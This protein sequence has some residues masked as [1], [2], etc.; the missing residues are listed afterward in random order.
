MGQNLIYLLDDQGIISDAIRG[1]FAA[2][3]RFIYGWIGSLADAMY[4][5]A[6]NDYLG[7]GSYAEDFAGKIFNILI[8]FMIFKLTITF[9]NYLVNPD[10][11]NDN[12]KGIQNVIKRIIICF[13]LLISINPIFKVLFDVQQNLIDDSVVENLML[14]SDSDKI[15]V[16]DEGLRIYFTQISPYCD[17]YEP[18]KRIITFS[19]GDHLALLTLKPFMQPVSE[20]VGD[21]AERQEKIK[22]SGYCGTDVDSLDGIAYV[23]TSE[24]AMSQSFDG[25]KSATGLLKWDIYNGATGKGI[26][27]NGFEANYY[28]IDFNYFIALIVGI[29]VSLI[30]I[31][32]CFDII[33]RAFTLMLLQIL[34]PIPIISY[35]SPGGKSADMLP[36]WGKK[37]MSTWASLFIRIIAL[38]FALSIISAI[39]ESGGIGDDSMGLL[40][41]IVIILGA[42]MFAKK[43]PQL[44]EELFPGLKLEGLKLN[45][46][47]RISEDAVGGKA[48]LGAGAAIG[49]AGLSAGANTIT[50]VGRAFNRN[51]WRDK[52]GNVTAGSV[53]RGLGNTIGSP[54]A[55]AASAGRRAFM[56][57]SRDGRIFNGLTQGHLEAQF[58][59]QQREDLS[60]KGSTM[61]GR[62]AADVN[63]WIGRENA[64]QRLNREILEDENALKAKKGELMNEKNN[65][66]EE[67]IR[68][69]NRRDEATK[70]YTK[71]QSTFQSLNDRMDKS[72][73]VD[74]Y[75]EN[76]NKIG[77][78][79]IKDEIE[80]LEWMKTSDFSSEV[81]AKKAELDRKYEARMKIATDAAQINSIKA[82]LEREKSLI[83]SES[84]K[85]EKLK[86][87][88]DYV[89]Q[90]RSDYVKQV[91]ENRGKDEVATQILDNIS[92][93]KANNAEI[94]NNADF[95]I[96]NVD[97]NGKSTYNKGAVY[98]AADKV[99]TI[100]N[101][102]NN[103]EQVLNEKLYN[104]NI[105]EQNIIAQERDIAERKESEEFVGAMADNAHQ[106][107]T[108]PQPENWLSSADIASSSGY[109]GYQLRSRSGGAPGGPGPG[110]PGPGGPH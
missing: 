12:N 80:K 44:L 31:T 87:Q 85:Q 56:K 5:F 4:R 78:I 14:G 8:I 72:G 106:R 100:S 52:N 53:L 3:I 57:T 18:N 11:F 76:G 107:V 25:I 47:K 15:F 61:G 41:K 93:I 63:R 89:N 90:L 43:L 9:L 79:K 54:F 104:I 77:E 2:I 33:I 65:I 99:T 73:I 95:N 36:T 109:G 34:A 16:T 94:A 35:V 103:E 17:E 20:D 19:K 86:V 83:S 26:I 88:N 67:K 84:I 30:L 24:F 29:V 75:D 46:F 92:S 13:A 71:L 39:C 1:F 110:A 64:A 81:E 49:A 23:D 59:K 10:A 82:E 70:D 102:F 66:N 50:G 68:L 40:M 74:R 97:E 98:K 6:N 62:L 55:G 32:F 21:F 37:L 22:D 91:I 69:Q 101:S 105:E 42:L 28:I 51:T 7:L 96:L 38:D 58:A 48:V 60:R 108:S 27:K 45:P